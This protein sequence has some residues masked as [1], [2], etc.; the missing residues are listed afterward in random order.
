MKNVVFLMSLRFVCKGTIFFTL[1]GHSGSAGNTDAGDHLH[2]ELWF[3][4][5][6]VDPTQY[7]N[8]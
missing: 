5:E 8:F 1:V 3:D 7:I 2:F 4:G 6:P